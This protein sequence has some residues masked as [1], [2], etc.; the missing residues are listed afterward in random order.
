MKN[1]K[2][3]KTNDRFCVPEKGNNGAERLVKSVSILLERN[4]IRKRMLVTQ[5]R[6]IM[7][8]PVVLVSSV[9]NL[10]RP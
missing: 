10:Q 5:S 4:E 6:R 8:V 2:N 9:C 1:E 7:V 3:E